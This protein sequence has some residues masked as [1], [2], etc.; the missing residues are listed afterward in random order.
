MTLYDLSVVL[1]YFIIDVNE[2]DTDNGGCNQTCVNEIG[3]YHCECDH[4]FLLSEDLQACIGMTNIILS[5]VNICK[6]SQWNLFIVV[7]VEMFCSKCVLILE[8]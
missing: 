3:S 2:C 5:I 8:V 6:Y 4:G 7:I 1:H